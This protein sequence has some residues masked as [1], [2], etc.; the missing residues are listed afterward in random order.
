VRAGAA[1]AAS[2]RGADE[3]PPDL[4]RLSLNQYTTYHWSVAEAVEGCA[5]AGLGWVGLWRDKVAAQ[6]LRDSVR[7]LRETGVHCSSLC[8]GGMFPAATAAERAARLDDNRRAIDECAELGAD[9]LVLVCGGIHHGGD[10]AAAREMVWDGIAAIAPDARER[11]VRLGIEP[12]HP[13][14]CADRSVVVTLGQANDAA[15]RLNEPFPADDPTV[16]VVVDAYHVWWDPRAGAEITRAGNRIFA[17]HVSDWITPLPAVLEGRG[18]MGDG[19]IGLREF[20]RAVDRAGYRGPIECEIFNRELWEQA[21][22]AVLELMK[23]R[24][25]AHV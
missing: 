17:F 16:G 21:G 23:A 20:R 4:G 2:E 11:G 1:G 12:L 9:T 15:D 22:D 10:V 25:L 6:G 19:W 3:A 18:M 8:R 5:R 24:Y 14:F 7:A 13:M